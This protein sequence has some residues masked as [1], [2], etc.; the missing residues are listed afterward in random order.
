MLENQM[1]VI[2]SVMTLVFGAGAIQIIIKKRHKEIPILS[3]TFILMFI[4]LLCLLILFVFSEIDDTLI[5]GCFICLFGFLFISAGV[6]HF[7]CL[8]R[9]KEKVSAKYCGYKLWVHRHCESY[10]PIFEYRYEGR[11]YHEVSSHTISNKKIIR[12]LEEG[13]MY[14][15]YIDPKFPNVFILYKKI[16]PWMIVLIGMGIFTIAACILSL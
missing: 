6:N 3:W 12:G 14:E 4:G 5:Y 7:Y 8:I 16:N 2:I 1:L 11:K 9:C 15:I 13:K 10:S